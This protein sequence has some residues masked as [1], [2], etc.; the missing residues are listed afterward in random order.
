MNDSS[1]NIKLSKFQLSKIAQLGGFLEYLLGP[2]L[3]VELP[4]RE[5][6]PKQLL[7]T[8]LITLGLP[9]PT[10]VS[11]TDAGFHK[12]IIGSGM[13]IIGK[14]HKNYGFLITVV[15]ETIENGSEVKFRKYY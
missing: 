6:V 2:L 8:T 4:L 9:T 3:R 15:T 13:T 7:K 10:D 1:A 12:T 14:H 11:P 5:N